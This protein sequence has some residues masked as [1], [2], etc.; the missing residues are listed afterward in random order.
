[1]QEEGHVL[2]FVQADIDI[3]GGAGHA[4]PDDQAG[5]ID[6]GAHHLAREQPAAELPAQPANQRGPASIRIEWVA[7]DESQSIEQ[8]HLTY[9]PAGKK[10]DSSS[11]VRD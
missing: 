7:H 4:G 10:N 8:G 9:I 3:A 5:V 6:E 1:M 11:L 2:E